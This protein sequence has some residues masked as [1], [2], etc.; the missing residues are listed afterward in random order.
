MTEAAESVRSRF[1]EVFDEIAEHGVGFH[2]PPAPSPD[3]D[4]MIVVE[5]RQDRH[6]GLVMR[7]ARICGMRKTFRADDLRDESQTADFIAEL[8]RRLSSRGATCTAITGD[9]HSGG[10]HWRESRRRSKNAPWCD[11]AY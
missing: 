10:T 3:G 8:R 9:W 6:F 1:V 7:G 4:A 2:I 11:A 5:H